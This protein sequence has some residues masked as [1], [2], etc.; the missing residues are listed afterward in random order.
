MRIDA[1]HAGHKLSQIELAIDL[2][3]LEWATYE[4]H[5][6]VVTFG[7]RVFLVLLFILLGSRNVLLQGQITLAL[8]VFIENGSETS[9]LGSLVLLNADQKPN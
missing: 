2:C 1:G 7:I 3:L 8:L 4:G 6:F 9:Q 5:E